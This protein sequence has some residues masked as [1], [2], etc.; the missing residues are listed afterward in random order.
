MRGELTGIDYSYDTNAKNARDSLQLV[1][2]AK[3]IAELCELLVTI[4]Y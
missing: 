1:A 4:Y 3:M 2:T